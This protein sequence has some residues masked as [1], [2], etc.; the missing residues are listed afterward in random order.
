[1]ECPACEEKR[2][3]RDLGSLVLPKPTEHRAAAGALQRLTHPGT[4][5]TEAAALLRHP[6]LLEPVAALHRAHLVERLSVEG[7]EVA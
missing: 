3:R 5:D 4:H 2:K 7:A 1:M 6:D